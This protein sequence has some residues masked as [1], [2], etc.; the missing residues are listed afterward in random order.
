MKT[1]LIAASALALAG[2]MS[3]AVV[4][5]AQAAAAKSPYCKMANIQRNLVSWNAYYH[6]NN[7]APRVAHVAVRPGPAKSPYCKMANIQRNLVSWNAYYHCNN[8]APR[9]PQA[10]LQRR[11]LYAQARLEQAKDPECKLAAG[12]RNLVSWNAYYHCL[13][14]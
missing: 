10:S 3:P 9:A 4:S 11:Q 7:P 14:R 12:Q 6:C 2:A 8:P 5:S 13:N 1:I